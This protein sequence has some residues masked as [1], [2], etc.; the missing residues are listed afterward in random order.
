MPDLSQKQEGFEIS[1]NPFDGSQFEVKILAPVSPAALE[2]LRSLFWVTMT[3]HRDGYLDF[4]VSHKGLDNEAATAMVSDILYQDQRASEAGRVPNFIGA[5]PVFRVEF[6]W[7]PFSNA[8]LELFLWF[9]VTEALAESFPRLIPWVKSCRW[10][11]P[12]KLSVE[13][14]HDNVDKEKVTEF[15]FHVL[16]Q[17]YFGE[18]EIESAFQPEPQFWLKKNPFGPHLFE[19]HTLFPVTSATLLDLPSVQEGRWINQFSMTGQ[20]LLGQEECGSNDVEEVLNALLKDIFGPEAVNL[21][22]PEP[23]PEDASFFDFVFEDLV[24]DFDGV[25]KD[26]LL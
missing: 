15:I 24:T 3:T 8:L 16:R 21:A 9:P 19:V 12:L 4:V 20:F 6:D 14:V 5:A 25:I 26:L 1:R 13:L 7:N 10:I 23:T 11:N 18:A 2:A 17:T 22:P